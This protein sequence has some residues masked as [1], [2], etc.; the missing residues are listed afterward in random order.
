LFFEMSLDKVQV[1]ARALKGQEAIMSF[2]PSVISAFVSV[3][4][5]STFL[6]S[7]NAFAYHNSADILIN[8]QQGGHHHRGHGGVG[9]GVQIGVPLGGYAA[10]SGYGQPYPYRAYPPVYSTYQSTTIISPPVVYVAPGSNPP[11][12]VQQNGGALPNGWWYYCP[13]PEG[14]YPHVQSCSQPWQAIE[15][16]RPGQ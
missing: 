8:S 3:A 1:I 6:L 10:Y 16:R 7:T 2:L 9:V 4:S 11:Q 5:L 14:Y 13:Q 12:I 15:P